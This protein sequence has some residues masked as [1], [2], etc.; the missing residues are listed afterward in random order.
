MYKYFSITLAITIY[1]NGFAQEIIPLYKGDI[2]NS[3][4]C[5][6]VENS[7]ASGSLQGV[8]IPTITAFYPEKKDSNK[9]VILIC[10]GG[11]YSNLA[12]DHEGYQV[13]KALNKKGIT[14]FVLKY[15]LPKDSSCCNNKELVALQDAQKAIQMIKEHSVEWDINANNFGVMGFSAGGHLASTVGTHFKTTTIENPMSTSLKPNFLMLIYPVIS[16][17][18]SLTH[19]GSRNNLLGLKPSLEKINAYSNQLQVTEETP[20]TFLLHAANDATVKVENSLQFYLA[21]KRNKVPAEIHILQKGSHGFGLKNK[22]EPLDWI[23]NVFAWL[24]ANTFIQ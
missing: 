7:T 13:A 5:A 17:D 21:L 2:I 19:K 14:A 8:T 12:I 22:Q 11:G 24:K 16:L 15:R 1:L 6:V 20:P 4:T 10:P 9:T 23:Q 3:K 18:D